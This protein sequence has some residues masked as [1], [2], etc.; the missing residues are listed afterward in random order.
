MLR[1]D[2]WVPVVPPGKCDPAHAP[3]RRGVGVAACYIGATITARSLATRSHAWTT[4]LGLARLS[5]GL[6][7]RFCLIA[8][9]QFTGAR[10]ELEM[11]QQS[12]CVPTAQLTKKKGR[13]DVGNAQRLGDKSPQI[14]PPR[15]RGQRCP[16]IA[17]KSRFVR[18]LFLTFHLLTA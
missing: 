17:P 7:D 6:L 16:K 15:Q 4:A 10:G 12:C 5:D 2:A 11:T 13:E 14:V 18:R 8:V 1:K 3:I 9:G